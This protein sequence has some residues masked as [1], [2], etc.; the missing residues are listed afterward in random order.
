AYGELNLSPQLA[1]L[2]ADAP[3]IGAYAKTAASAFV[4]AGIAYISLVIGELVPK[5]VALSN[6][7]RIACTVAPAMSALAMAAAPIALLLR[8][9]N[10]GVRRFG[11]PAV[12]EEPD[13][14]EEEV[15]SMI[16]EGTEAGVFEKAEQEIIERLLGVSG[17]SVRSIMV[18]RPDIV[19]LDITES[20]ERLY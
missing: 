2:L 5:Q 12:R 19:W 13:V 16:A 15:K 7:E 8:L 17:R 10:T 11:R 4:I 20:D 1:H 18:P 9:A 3:L 14:T 6:R